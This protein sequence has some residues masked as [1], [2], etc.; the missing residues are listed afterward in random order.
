MIGTKSVS[1]VKTIASEILS[2]LGILDKS[3]V[4]R[5]STPFC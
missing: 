3:I 5:V 2:L 4:N 1:D